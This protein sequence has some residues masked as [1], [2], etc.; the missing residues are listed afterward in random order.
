M[1]YFLFCGPSARTWTNTKRASYNCRAASRASEARPMIVFHSDFAMYA[2]Y[3]RNEQTT[4][5]DAAVAQALMMASK[6]IQL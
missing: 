1:G 4:Q 3:S 2:I 5:A 6:V